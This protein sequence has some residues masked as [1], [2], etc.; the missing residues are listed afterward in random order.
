MIKTIQ[1]FRDLPFV[2]GVSYQTKFATG[3]RFTITKIVM[4]N[5]TLIGFKG[6]YENS[7]HLG[8]CPLAADRLIP[9]RVVDGTV[10]VCSKCNTEI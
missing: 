4:Q 2:E 3:E 9:M 8:V 7:P 10:D 6:F 1:K 5:N